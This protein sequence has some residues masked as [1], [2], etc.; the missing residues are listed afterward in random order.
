M[1]SIVTL[2]LSPAL[3]SATSIAHLVP[4]RKLRCSEPTYAP[5]GGGINVARAIQNLGGRALAVFPAGGPTGAHLTDLLRAE[6][7]DL[8][9]IAIHEWTRQCFNV[10]EQA[11]AQQYRF[12]LPGATL[13]PSEQEAVLNA[14][15]ALEPFSYLVISGSLPEGLTEDFMPRLLQIA[16]DKGARSILDTSGPALEQAVMAGGLFL[17][18]PSL[19]ELGHLVGEEITQPDQLARVT[20]NLIRAGK[21]E[22]L[23]VSMGAQGAL[24][25]TRDKVERISAPNVKKISTVGAGDSLLAAMVLKLSEGA[26][27]SEAAHYGVAAGSASIMSSGTNLCA[28]DETDRLFTWMQQHQPQQAI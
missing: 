10:D 12:V 7:V 23:M 2:T 15:A 18:K 6:G 28:K 22:M 13:N 11:H 19:S 5:G 3:D 26:S 4:D 25:V 27:A 8:R 20:G 24:L 9:A 21:C 17:I 14:I 1:H 16:K